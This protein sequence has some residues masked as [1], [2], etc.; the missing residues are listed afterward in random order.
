M[1][2]YLKA[3]KLLVTINSFSNIAGY[4]INLQKSVAILYTKNEQAEKE[5]RKIIPF[6]I[7]SKKI[8]IPRNKL[9]RR[10]K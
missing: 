4:K 1:I 5:C 8:K 2:L 9:N 6:T 7:A 10:C 3:K